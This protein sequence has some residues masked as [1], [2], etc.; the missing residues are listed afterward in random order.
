MGNSS[1]YENGG[2]AR[3]RLK[4]KALLIWRIALVSLL[5]VLISLILKLGV[6]TTLAMTGLGVA[7]AAAGC[8]FLFQNRKGFTTHDNL[9]TNLVGGGCFLLSVAILALTWLR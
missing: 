3:A 1:A 7:L 2:G 9:M 4:P 5:V 8:S 6:I